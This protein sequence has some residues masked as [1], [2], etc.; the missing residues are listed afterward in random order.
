M[1][2]REWWDHSL[3]FLKVLGAITGPMR[4]LPQAFR[5]PVCNPQIARLR[6]HLKFCASFSLWIGNLY[7]FSIESANLH[8]LLFFP[9]SLHRTDF[10]KDVEK[11]ETIKETRSANENDAF[12]LNLHWWH[13]MRFT[14]HPVYNLASYAPGE[15]LMSWNYL[16]WLTLHNACANTMPTW[17]THKYLRGRNTV[18][19]PNTLI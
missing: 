14:K 6:C 17:A 4:M 16:L 18:I 19:F 12:D 5:P 2:A 10:N 11:S 13:C 7:F 9:K 3:A 15:S 8:N 1:D